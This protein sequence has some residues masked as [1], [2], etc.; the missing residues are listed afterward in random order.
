ME[1]KCTFG[2]GI[3]VA[4]PSS[5]LCPFSLSSE[6]TVRSQEGKLKTFHSLMTKIVKH[7]N[8][9]IKSQMKASNTGAGLYYTNFDSV[10][11]V[12]MLII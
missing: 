12:I 11:T 8:T 3:F 1:T 2:E 6:S 5:T 10:N 4:S 7:S 9:A